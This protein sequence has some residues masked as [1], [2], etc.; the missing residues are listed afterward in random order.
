M[1]ETVEVVQGDRWRH[2][3]TVRWD[4]T[5]HKHA[6]RDRQE[7]SRYVEGRDGPKAPLEKGPAKK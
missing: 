2:S 6:A 3:N 7:L 1:E 5:V 4:G